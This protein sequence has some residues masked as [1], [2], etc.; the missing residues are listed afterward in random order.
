MA[1][2]LAFL[3]ALLLAVPAFAA[4]PGTVTPYGT[5]C[6][7][8]SPSHCVTVD[9]SGNLGITGSISATSAATATAANPSYVEGT[10]NPLSQDLSGHLRTITGTGS[11]TAVTGN[12]T[13]VQGTGSNL[14]T[15]IDS[16]TVAATQSGTWTV[17]G[18]GG[19]F[20]VT[21]STSPWIVAGG[22]T[23]GTA[24]TGVVTVQ[25]IASMTPVQV[26][27]ATASNLNATVVGTGTFATQSAITAA[28]GSIASGA[29]SSGAIASGAFASGAVSSGAFASGSMA[30]GSQVDITNLSTPLT[31]ATATAT[32]GVLLGCRNQTAPDTATDTQQMAVG[33]D[34]RT[35]LKTTLYSANSA[36]AI[37][38]SAPADTVTTPTA[39]QVL[40]TRPF[41]E[42]YNGSSHDL[43]RSVA[44]ST[45]STGTGITAA[46]ILAQC[47]DTSPTAITENSFGNV[48]M[49]CTN[50]SLIVSQAGTGAT[51]FT[52]PN[53][54]TAYAA[55]DA[56]SDSTSAPTSGGFTLSGACRKSGGIGMIQSVRFLMST[57][58]ATSLQG[59]IWLFNQ[60][61]TNINDNSAFSV[62]DADMANFVG[63]IPFT[64]SDGATNNASA[65]VANVNLSYTCT[66]SA[67]LRYLVK[68]VN[69]YTPAAQ[70]I[71]TVTPAYVF[72]N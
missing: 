70:E 17:T 14:H 57:A 68:V 1:R 72:L 18:A 66:G 67:N 37:I 58:A 9:S 6:D 71:L 11:T 50:H 21:Q 15:V 29:I 36:T 64:T 10:S 49:D 31:A 44:N 2:I 19:T 59:E 33:C 45:N 32:K 3:T 8:R 22:G 63:K 7:W 41:P 60:S 34:T 27:Q 55:N 25:G 42:I 53:D 23:A 30:A 28:S 48:A 47:D 39:G 65:T 56:M 40:S 16:G 69:V 4:P 35:N 54:T 52:R 43:Q 26:S 5:I 12:V 61:V 62:S 46:G 38:A 13:V 20:P 24:A 51:S